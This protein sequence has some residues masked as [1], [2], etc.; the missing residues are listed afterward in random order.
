M[1]IQKVSAAELRKV[2]LH[3]TTITNQVMQLIQNPDAL[4]IWVYLL[5][6][7]EGWIVRPTDLKKR[8]NLSKGRYSKA[9]NELKDLGLC[10]VAIERNEKGQIQSKP[11]VCSSLPLD[12]LG[13]S[14]ISPKTHRMD[15]PAGGKSDHIIKDQLVNKLS[16]INKGKNKSFADQVH[17]QAQQAFNEIDGFDI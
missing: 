2:G 9:M 5:S 13:D 6:Q 12:W 4:A 17:E 11:L 3:Y 1:A 14:A 15:K 8:F 16:T 10:F 7:S